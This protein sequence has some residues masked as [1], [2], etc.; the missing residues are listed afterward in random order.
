M[1]EVEE[2]MRYLYTKYGCG[3]CEVMKKEFEA[4]GISYEERDAELITSPQDAIDA[5]AFVQAA[6]QNMKLACGGYCWY[7]EQMI[8]AEDTERNNFVLWYCRYATGEDIRVATKNNKERFDRL[9]EKYL[10]DVRLVLSVMDK[11]DPYE[12]VREVKGNRNST[13]TLTFV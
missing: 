5:E 4:Q 1:E 10:S 11:K 6:Q 12:E 2:G 13:S 7:G 3:K 9:R 8:M